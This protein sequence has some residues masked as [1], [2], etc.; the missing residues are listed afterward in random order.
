MKRSM[1]LSYLWRTLKI[2]GC[3]VFALIFLRTFV[4]ETGRVNGVSMETTFLDNETFFVD[5]FSL[6]VSPPSRGQVIQCRNPL[7][8]GGLLIKRVIGLPGEYVRVHGNAVTVVDANG[9]EI[10]LNETYVKAGAITQTWNFES[11]DYP[12]IG[13]DEYFVLGDNRRESGDSRNFGPIKRVDIL[14]SVISA[15]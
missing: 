8:E 1:F 9:N 12:L 3:V 10:R 4:I 6:L 11:G 13:P 5:K 2:V 7:A 15:L 14:G